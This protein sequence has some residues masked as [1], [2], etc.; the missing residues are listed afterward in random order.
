MTMGVDE[1]KPPL[2]RPPG[3]ANRQVA[4]VPSIHVSRQPCTKSMQT[5][6]IL[7]CRRSKAL[8]ADARTFG[9]SW[10][11]SGLLPAR[12]FSAKGTISLVVVGR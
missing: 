6:C 7:I 5:P 9:Q 12:S 2:R 3:A 11:W 8:Q 10:F 4:T 1:H